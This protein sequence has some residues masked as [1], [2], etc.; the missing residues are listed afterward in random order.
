MAASVTKLQIQS[1]L[2]FAH[3]AWCQ[4]TPEVFFKEMFD[5]QPM[6]GKEGVE[7]LHRANAQGKDSV[8]Q[9]SQW[10]WGQWTEWQANPLKWYAGL[11]IAYRERFLE[12]LLEI[13]RGLRGGK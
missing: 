11:D 13:Q 2:A 6:D 9:H 12:A 1:A 5:H 8:A 10:L 4:W 7:H 3:S